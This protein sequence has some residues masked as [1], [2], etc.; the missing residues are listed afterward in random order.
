MFSFGNPIPNHDVQQNFHISSVGKSR[1]V[2]AFRE[3]FDSEFRR[4]FRTEVRILLRCAT[5]LCATPELR[6]NTFTLW[7]IRSRKSGLGTRLIWRRK[8]SGVNRIRTAMRNKDFFKINVGLWIWK[9]TEGH[10]DMMSQYSR[11]FPLPTWFF[12]P[13]LLYCTLLKKLLLIFQCLEPKI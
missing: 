8:K 10:K 9:P 3:A 5:N 1:L 6:L 13:I 11:Y 2:I 12:D 4:C 7:R